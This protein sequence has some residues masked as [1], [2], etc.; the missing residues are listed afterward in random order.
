MAV[1]LLWQP[2]A[3]LSAGFWLSFGLVGALIWATAGRKTPRD[4][5][6]YIHNDDFRLPQ[7]TW[8]DKLRLAAQAQWAATL[9]GGVATIAL[10][11]LLPVF[12]PLA[13]ALAIPL[14]S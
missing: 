3:A 12:S 6:D 7:L 2:A 13:N 8:R 4:V 1:V 10:F 14:F 9:L 11:G 5:L